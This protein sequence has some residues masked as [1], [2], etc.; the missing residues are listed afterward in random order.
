MKLK[1]IWFLLIAVVLAVG[2]SYSAYYLFVHSGNDYLTVSEL[3]AQA[4][5]F[6]DQKVRVGGKVVPGS[7]RWDEMTKVMKFVLTDNQGNL[8]VAYEGVVPDY[9]KPGIDV[10]VS[11]NYRQDNV[12]NAF[13]F[14]TRRSVC[15]LCH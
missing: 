9:F 3:R 11:G 14:G 7:I 5:S 13:S 8:A 10:V 15:S 2:L 12:F 4:D 1:K 6:T